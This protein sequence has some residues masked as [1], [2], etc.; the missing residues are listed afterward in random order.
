M[1]VCHDGLFWKAFILKGGNPF[2][3]KSSQ[4]IER[5]EKAVGYSLLI[6]GLVLI[7]LPACL[8]LWMFQS[9]TQIPQLVPTGVGETT[10]F[11]TAI[12]IFS[13]MCL[14]AFIFIILVWAGS[15]LSSRGVA[16]V[17]DVKLKLVRKS[18]DEANE[19]VSKE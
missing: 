1:F 2:S 16:M 5:I 6:V 12:A 18:L 11:T 15:I 14:A 7:V 3:M 10:E 4:K 9:G 8:A 19:A 13:N 17:K